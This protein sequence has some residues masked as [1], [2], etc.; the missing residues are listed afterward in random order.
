MDADMWFEDA[1]DEAFLFFNN[2]NAMWP[3]GVQVLATTD[4]PDP[5]G[6]LVSQLGWMERLKLGV[7]FWTDCSED[8][9]AGTFCVCVAHFCFMLAAYCTPRNLLCTVD[10]S[11]VTNLVYVESL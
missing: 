2:W 5:T 11:F 9:T 4:Q 1:G 3:Q 8:G 7:S 10:R 6:I